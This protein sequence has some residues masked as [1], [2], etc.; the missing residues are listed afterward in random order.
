MT[1]ENKKNINKKD[2]NKLIENLKNQIKKK[3]N[4]LKKSKNEKDL[5]L[6]NIADLQNQKKREDKNYKIETN[7]LKKRYLIEIIDILD[8][9]NK[10]YDDKNPKIGIKLIINQI[11]KFLD[12]EN[13]KYIEC[14]GKT[15][16]HKI[17]HAITTIEKKD[18]E[19]EI[20]I[21][22]LKKGYY[23]NDEILR[24]SHVIVSKK[25]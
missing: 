4:L 9:I 10:A 23:I 6:R 8:L 21:D 24:P 14:L 5:L 17:H 16:N 3:N 2:S 18:C 7:I 15:F 20:I 11:E 22:E 1:V 19:D 25:K 13:I 12:N